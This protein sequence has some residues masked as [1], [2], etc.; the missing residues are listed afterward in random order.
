MLNLRIVQANYGDCFIL[1][2][3]SDADKRHMLID[4]GPVNVYTDD[5]RSEIE[6]VSANGG[7]LDLVVVSHVDKDHIVGILDLFA[8]LLNQRTNGDPELVTVG[9]LWHNAFS[10]SIDPDGTIQTR[11]A[12]SLSAAG[13]N[14]MQQAG[15]AINGV[16][17]GRRLRI[18]ATQLGISIN[19]VFPNRLIC[20]DDAPDNIVFENLTLTIVGPTRA[21]LDALKDEWVEWLDANETGVAG[22]DPQIMANADRSIPNLS[23]VVFLAEAEGKTILFTGDGRSDHLMDGLHA[24]NLLDSNERLHVDVLKVA[25]HGSNRNA[26]R[27]FHRKVTADTYVI[28]ANGHPDNPDLSTLIWIV[29]AAR[30][31]SRQ[32]KIVATNRTGSLDKLEEEYPPG[33]YGYQLE[34]MPSHH[35][36]KRLVLA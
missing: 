10:D 31:Q 24:A 20:T 12:A 5:L 14:I 34:V 22:G 25:H 19:D 2:Y 7:I 18:F 33:D 13:A 6:Y 8:N 21:N 17:E 30:E 4:G 9:G 35:S 11:L 1:E 36:Y 23:S 32:I 29:E 16:A 26:T 28:S 27:T 3:G 15:M